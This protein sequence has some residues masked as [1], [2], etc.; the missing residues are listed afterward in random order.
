MNNAIKREK[1]R[2]KTVETKS[3]NKTLR[4][5]LA[6][7]IIWIIAAVDAV[8]M[9]QNVQPIPRT[10]TGKIISADDNEPIP[11]ANIVI[12]GTQK[13]TTT[14]LDGNFSIA[15]SE[16]D[17]LQ[18]SFIGY[19]TEEISV[20]TSDNYDVSMVLDIA[21]LD[22]VVV[23][24]YG[25]QKKKLVTGATS[26]VKGDDL[27]RMNALSPLAAL[28]GQTPGV[29]ITSNSAQPGEGFKVSIRGIGTTDYFTP[30]FIVDGVQVDNIS[31][32]NNAD[33]EAV[34]VLKDA[35][36]AAIYGNRAANGVV[37]ITTRQGKEGQSVITYDGYIGIQNV[38]KKLDLLN[39]KQYSVIM[40]EMNRNN[41]KSSFD[42][43]SLRVDLNAIGEGTDWLDL[44]FVKN[45]PT[46]NHVI[47]ASGG[48]EKSVYSL[49][50]SYTDQAG[51]V[52]GADI[53]NYKRFSFRINTDHKMNKFVT[54]GQHLIYS[55]TNKKGIG[56][57]DLYN[58]GLHVAY[59]V[60]P[61][62][63]VYD[64]EG[65]YFNSNAKDENGQTVYKWSNDE[66]NPYALLQINNQKVDLNHHVIGDI[67]AIIEPVKG[68]KYKTSLGINLNSGSNHRFVPK[69]AFSTNVL[70]STAFAEQS[71]WG[72]ITWTWENTLSYDISVGA[73]SFSSLAGMSAQKTKG[74]TQW[75]KNSGLIF[76]DFEHAWISNAKNVQNNGILQLTGRPYEN[77]ALASYFGRV[78]YDYKETYLFN[79][80]LRVDGSS[81]F[82]PGRRWGYFPSFSAGWVISNE[83]FYKQ[84]QVVDFLK[85][86]ASWGQNGNENIRSFAY[87]STIASGENYFFGD[88][89]LATLASYPDTLANE[90]I[91]WETS[92]QLNI[93]FDMRILYK[94]SVN[95]DY[96]IKKTKDWL[97]E[98]PISATAG[99]A[100]PYVNGGDV[101][102]SGIELAF[103]WNDNIGKINYYVNA[104]IAYNKNKVTRI[105]N[106]EGIIHGP[107]NTLWQGMGEIY[108]A[109]VGYP[110]GYFWGY[111]TDG[112]FQ[113]PQEV[114]NHVNADGELLQ[115]D[116][117][118]GDVR[119][120]DYNNDGEIT[121][122]D[123][124][125]IGNPHPDYIFGLNFGLSF[126]GVD[127]SVTSNGVIGNQIAK[128]FR[129][130]ER[131]KNN[132]TTEAMGRWRGEGSSDFF[133]RVIEKSADK[134]NNWG[135]FSPLYLESGS[136]WRLTNITVG[137]DFASLLKKLPGIS[138]LRLYLTA[139][140]LYT[141]TKYSGMDPDVGYAQ[142]TW[143][144]GIDLGFYPHP[145][146]FLVGL[147]MKF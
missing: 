37:L 39:A 135:Y 99:A 3:E 46:Q 116:A 45:A 54:I 56:V 40:D 43:A 131:M 16:G 143:G 6:F 132:W 67:Y 84:M 93:G 129:S 27:T 53:S 88:D 89:D 42:Y 139:Q 20:G 4:F 107:S 17:V 38:Y 23:V 118:P 26:H 31:Y 62:L 113:N 111:E 7:S 75:S 59:N 114:L 52:G 108:R 86:R 64:D 141:L 1:N 18:I 60:S 117:K 101:R 77:H 36:S 83:S 51:I 90:N 109:E 133:P 146:T 73:H 9:A 14:D 91:T 11:G 121:E 74:S 33:I 119:F 112:L 85:L 138:Q 126:K 97:V 49:S 30:L 5:L 140:N 127:F 47:S 106:A 145:R 76:D 72:G 63:P 65:E 81:N 41:G 22:E 57:G 48:T 19:L 103:G 35:A 69:Y 136:Y 92:Q 125:E 50:L 68:I 95:F 79:A 10:I 123:R 13:G 142:K 102:N 78:L 124:H 66:A 2:R 137:Y 71:T 120:V 44:L 128:G 96:Y 24:G 70:N 29:S 28:Q 130:M 87:L 115:E 55:H 144:S 104:N 32:L 94:M 100:A 21:R 12:M 58:N 147:N 25:V 110:I 34:D 98:A 8:V 15:A 82:A 134:N 61:F 80:T 122:D 105:D